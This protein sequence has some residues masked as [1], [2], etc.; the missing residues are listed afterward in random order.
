[1]SSR[2]LR[3]LQNEKEV[4][5][6]VSDTDVAS[7]AAPSKQLNINRYDLVCNPHLL[8]H[9]P[10][11]FKRVQQCFHHFLCQIDGKIMITACEK[12]SLKTE[13]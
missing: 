2:V 3:K 9:I 10:L 11:Y 6:Q 5:E 12:I 7:A 1:M 4:V 8:L 13:V